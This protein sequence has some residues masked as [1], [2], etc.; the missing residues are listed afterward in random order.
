MSPKFH[1]GE[2]AVQERAGVRSEAARIGKSLQSTMPPAAREFLR[3]RE[4]IVLGSLDDAGRV[5]ASLLTGDP[6]FLQAPDEHTLNVAASIA[7]GDPLANNLRASPQVGTLTMDLA[8]RRRMRLNGD[9]TLTPD[10]ITIQAREVMSLC[11][12]YIQAREIQSVSAIAANAALPRRNRELQAE[13]QQLL[14]AADTFFL[15]T[16]AEG[17]ADVSHRGGNPG[18]IR[19]LNATTLAWPDY[20]GNNMFQTLGNLELNP[21]AGLLF[22]DFRTGATLQLTGKCQVIWDADHAAEYPG[23]QRLMEFHI[24]EVLETASATGLRWRLLDYSPFNP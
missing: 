19:V 5:W 2:L 4:F 11:P 8:T 24:E 23:A 13:Q 12:K 3:H 16:H 18:F 17:G 22:V 7:P 20:R 1:A 15:A 10:G 6:G 21:N 14:S 9:A